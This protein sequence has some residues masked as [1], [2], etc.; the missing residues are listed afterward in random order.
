MEKVFGV[1]DII[2]V[3]FVHIEKQDYGIMQEYSWNP[4]GRP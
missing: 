4:N 1:E 3:R 2:I